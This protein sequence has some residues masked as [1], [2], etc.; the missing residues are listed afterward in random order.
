MKTL[1]I[2]FLLIAAAP[3]RAQED[4]LKTINHP[5]EP[6]PFGVKLRLPEKN[7]RLSET[8]LSNEDKEAETKRFFYPEKESTRPRLEWRD[9]ESGFDDKRVIAENLQKKSPDDDVDSKPYEKEKFHWKPALIQSGVLLGIQH[10]FRLIQ[11]KTRREFG[12]P[13]FRDWGNSI[14]NLRGWRDGDNLFT[15]YVGHPL[16]GAVTGRIFINNSNR[17]L[18]QEFGKSKAYWNSRLKA[19]AWSAAWSIQF[20]LGP[21]SEAN[22][23]N[24]GLR[25]EPDYS[26]MAYVDLVITP[27]VGT[28]I[29]VGEDAI[30]KYILKNLFERKTGGR[31]TTKI[32]LLRTF[33]TPATSFS[34]LLRGKVP[35]KRD[36]R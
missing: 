25:T 10:S 20:E 23:G 31:L 28:A 33:L 11:R 7:I 26:P 9:A 3:T 17:S 4:N 6:N 14:K 36:Y 5:R 1:L 2:L 8:L 21:V 34:N 30:D 19:M 29:V 27:V 12:G 35:W 24:V 18:K 22:I 15:N 16:Q 13:F 32:K